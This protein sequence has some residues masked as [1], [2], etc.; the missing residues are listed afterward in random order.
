MGT[1]RLI[2]VAVGIPLKGH[3]PP[4]AY[5]DRLL[6]AF[7]MGEKEQ[8]Q[9]LTNAPVLYEFNWFFVG[10]IFVPYARENL[11]DMALRYG[12]E[13]LFMVDDDMLAPFDL[14]Y[15]LVRHDRDI[16]GALAF[17]RNP[18]HNPVIYTTRKG[19]D[20]V[21]QSRYYNKEYVINYPRNALVEC[22]AVGFGAVLIKTELFKKMPKP[23]FMS[24]DACGED[25]LFCTKAKEAGFRVY[26]DTTQK[27]GHI[28]DSIIVTEEYSDNFNKLSEQDREDKY[29]KYTRCETLEK[30]R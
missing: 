25:V 29:G 26:M 12:C 17:T 28:S 21:A 1:Q 22:D 6:M 30:A 3:S 24:S 23:W 20:A 8:E 9:R 15:Q 7:C 2:K 27:L 11:A 5:N 19:W 10:E 18:P 4:K 13:Y 14:F 16:V